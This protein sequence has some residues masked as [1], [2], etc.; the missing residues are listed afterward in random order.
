MSMG[1]TGSQ[2]SQNCPDHPEHDYPTHV[3]NI[4]HCSVLMAVLRYALSTQRCN[5]TKITMD[6]SADSLQWP[7][8]PLILRNTG[9]Q[10]AVRL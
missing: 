7:A 3:Q 1:N 10:C 5:E 9:Q 2:S 6:N 4:R 8:T